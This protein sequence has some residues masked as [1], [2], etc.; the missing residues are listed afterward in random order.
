MADNKS[1]FITYFSQFFVF[2]RFLKHDKHKF[3]LKLIKLI[4]LT[5]PLHSDVSSK[6]N[7]WEETLCPPCVTNS[8][9]KRVSADD[10]FLN[11]QNFPKLLL[12]TWL[13]SQS[14]SLFPTDFI[15]LAVQR[16]TS[17][18][19]RWRFS[20][21]VLFSRLTRVRWLL[22]AARSRHPS[23]PV[24]KTRAGNFGTCYVSV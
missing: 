10:S 1:F 12:S 18:G 5:F 24:D 7:R 3:N 22:L 23:T 2:H 15:L 8:P 17:S 20:R 14:R 21:G 16:D 6:K 11:F 4:K 9:G 19:L 13:L